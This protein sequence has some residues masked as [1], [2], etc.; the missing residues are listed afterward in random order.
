M[1]TTFIILSI[2]FFTLFLTDIPIVML[3]NVYG[4]KRQIFGIELSAAL[5]VSACV[6]CLL[7]TL[8]LYFG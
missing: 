3:V 5:F 1:I 4:N 7:I 6:I 8:G 2:M